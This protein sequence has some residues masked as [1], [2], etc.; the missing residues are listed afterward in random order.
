M[1]GTSY[2]KPRIMP[3]S[4][5]KACHPCGICGKKFYRRANLVAHVARHRL[6]FDCYQCENPQ[7]H[8]TNDDLVKHVRRFHSA[9]T[10]GG[11][12]SSFIDDLVEHVRPFHSTDATGGAESSTVFN[13]EWEIAKTGGCADFPM[14]RGTGKRSSLRT[15]HVKLQNTES[16]Q[17]TFE[18]FERI[19]QSL[20]EKIIPHNLPSDYV[21]V[22][23]DSDSLHSPIPL[24]YRRVANLN[25]GNLF[26]T[27]KQ[28]L[29][30]NSDQNFRLDSGLRIQVD[31]I[32]RPSGS[33]GG[34]RHKR[35]GKY[36][37]FDAALK[38]KRSIIRI[39]EDGVVIGSFGIQLLCCDI[40]IN[41]T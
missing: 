20:L 36:S 33:G 21:G 26:N 12:E 15:Y 7:P 18:R 29:S 2:F 24:H 27:I 28:G 4:E 6:G 40:H 8:L 3:A 10:T 34:Q 11:T 41:L 14:K 39:R 38:S 31:H 23:F 17:P 37:D 1:S 25:A 13:P 19:F 30:S 22:T 35:V 16:V 32:R 5:E 9:D